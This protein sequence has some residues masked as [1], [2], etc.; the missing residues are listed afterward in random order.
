MAEAGFWKTE[1]FLGATAVICVVLRLLASD[2]IPR[3]AAFLGKA[4]VGRAGQRHQSG[5]E[6]A[7]ALHAVFGGRGVHKPASR[8][9]AAWI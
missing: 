1:W 6:R 2:P 8:M 5:A 7:A 4:Q 3:L 9:R